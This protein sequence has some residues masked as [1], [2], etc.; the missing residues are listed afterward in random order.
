MK[1]KTKSA[2]EETAENNESYWRLMA[3]S[4]NIINRMKISENQKISISG[5]N[6]VAEMKISW[7]HIG[8]NT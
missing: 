6:G 5:V 4:A 7:R 1:E 2:K 8:E 3:I